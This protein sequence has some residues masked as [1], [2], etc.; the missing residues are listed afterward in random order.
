[1]AARLSGRAPLGD[2][3]HQRGDHSK[4]NSLRAEIP[5]MEI[6]VGVADWVCTTSDIAGRALKGFLLDGSGRSPETESNDSS[7]SLSHSFLGVLDWSR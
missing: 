7:W 3:R 6:M 1:M 5:G 2:T 4:S